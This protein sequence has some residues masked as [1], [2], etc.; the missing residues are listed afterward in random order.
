MYG[1]PISGKACFYCGVHRRSL[2]SVSTV[3]GVLVYVPILPPLKVFILHPL[4]PPPPPPLENFPL[5]LHSLLTQV[6][7]LRPP[8]GISKDLPWGDYGYFLE[9]HI[10]VWHVLACQKGVSLSSFI[11]TAGPKC[12]KSHFEDLNFKTSLGEVLGAGGTPDFK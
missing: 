6:W 8:L 3:C 1:T 2:A 12:W 10:V 5:Y 11:N 9:S 4:T 7:L